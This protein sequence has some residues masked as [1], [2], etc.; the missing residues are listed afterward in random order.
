MTRATLVALAI[1]LLPVSA[2]AQD[3]GDVGI[4]MGYPATIAV[5]YHASDRIAIRPE[6]NVAWS[7]SKNVDGPSA[8]LES[9]G[10]TLG[11]GLSGLFY[12]STAD[13]LR[14]YVS[15]GVRYSRTHS[16]IDLSASQTAE[17]TSRSYQIAGSFGAQYSL[18]TRFSVF[19]EVGVAYSWMNATVLSGLSLPE[20]LPR[21]NEGNAFGTRTAVGVVFYFK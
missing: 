11:V 19:G 16:E 18:G 5:V 9:S 6:F 12:T 20:A 13:N 1:L 15:P 3:A 14:T 7:S 10:V 17:T 2:T 21:E 4:S 8:A